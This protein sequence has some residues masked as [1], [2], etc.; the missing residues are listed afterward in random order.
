MDVRSVISGGKTMRGVIEGDAVPQEFIP[1]L[2][3]LRDEGRLP[4]EKLIRTYEFDEIDR[5]FRRRRER[6]SSQARPQN[7]T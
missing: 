7:L 1:R 4:L 6:R 2:I 3:A 5:G